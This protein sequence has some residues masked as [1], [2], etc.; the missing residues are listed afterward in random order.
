MSH[1]IKP[2]HDIKP[3]HRLPF[4]RELGVWHYAIDDAHALRDVSTVRNPFPPRET[5]DMKAN[6]SGPLSPVTC[7]THCPASWYY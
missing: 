3:V 4:K 5:T 2:V 1:N 6:L 7:I